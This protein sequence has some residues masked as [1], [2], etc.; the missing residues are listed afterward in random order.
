MELIY[1]IEKGFTVIG[2]GLVKIL[3][4]K[5]FSGL[6]SDV[7]RINMKLVSTNGDSVRTLSY[8]LRHTFI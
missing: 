7:I 6:A 1:V 4:V 8:V 2:L 3:S 5:I